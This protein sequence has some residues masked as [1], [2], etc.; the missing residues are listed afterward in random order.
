MYFNT[1]IAAAVFRNCF[2]IGIVVGQLGSYVGHAN[3]L[4]PL[5]RNASFY[6]ITDDSSSTVGGKLPFGRDILIG[7]FCIIGMAF[8][9]NSETFVTRFLQ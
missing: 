1:A 4:Q 5:R 6:E 9:G 8:N 7:S 3:N 2:I